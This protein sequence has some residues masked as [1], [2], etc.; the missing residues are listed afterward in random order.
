MAVN[1]PKPDAW[2]RVKTWSDFSNIVVQAE[3]V[4]M[5]TEP[6]G[7]DF[8]FPLVF[9]PGR[10]HVVGEDVAA[11][12][13]LVVLLQGIEQ[14]RPANQGALGTCASSSGGIS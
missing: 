12:Q 14:L 2:R 4:R 5:R 3:L 1:L 13:E 10:D 7:V 8:L 6:H 11:E 9:D